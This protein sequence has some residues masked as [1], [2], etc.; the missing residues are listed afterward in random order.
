MNMRPTRPRTLGEAPTSAGECNHNEG[1]RTVTRREM[2][3]ALMIL[4]RRW[5]LRWLLLARSSTVKL[6]D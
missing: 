1:A 6:R 4:K 5:S 3:A 2:N